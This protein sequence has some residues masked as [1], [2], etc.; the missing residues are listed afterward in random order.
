[1]SINRKD[2]G[3]YSLYTIENAGGAKL[4]VT[5]CGAT[6]QSIMMPDRNGVLGDVV[7][8]FDVGGLDY[9]LQDVFVRERGPW[10]C[11]RRK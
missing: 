5:D 11:R 3:A 8:G 2:F 10:V 9:A 6:V 4:S 1:M 7:V